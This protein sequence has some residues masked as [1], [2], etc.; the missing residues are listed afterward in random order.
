VK[1]AEL[2]E[3]YSVTLFC[4]TP[5]FLRSYLRKAE[6]K[7]LASVQYLVTGA[8]KLPSELA[9]AFKEQFGM[10]ILQGYG[11]TETSPVAAVNLPEPKAS[12]PGDAVQPSNRAGSVGKLAPGMA[13]EIRHPET[14][15]KLSL[16][17]TGMLWLR[18][19]N[20]FE[21]Y[22]DAPAKTADVLVD[23]WFKTGDLARFDE[24][25]FCFIEGRLSRFSKIG[26]EMVPHETV[27]SKISEV[28]ALPKDERLI[29]IAGIP[30]EAKGEALVLLAAHDID[31]QELRKKLSDA[32][33]PNLWIPRIVKR[34]EAI[35]ILASGKLD[36]QKVKDLALEK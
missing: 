13:A 31:P 33:V 9:E 30:D 27:E 17:D 4:T 12:R 16:H 24:D 35:P 8:E 25:G 29:A 18:G 21:S 7:Q 19:P 23:R 5:T 2:I 11:L 15:E 14:D 28:L 32:G 20:I 6:P 3:R 1:N 36:L 22:L 34:V 10:Q 26:G